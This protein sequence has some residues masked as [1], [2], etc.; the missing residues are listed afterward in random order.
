MEQDDLPAVPV[1]TKAQA[2][3]LEFVSERSFGWG[4]PVESI[5]RSPLLEDG[6]GVLLMNLIKMGLLGYPRGSQ[7]PICL[8]GF[9][10]RALA[11]FRR[12]AKAAMS[13]G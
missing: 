10:Q 9:G 11:R 12:K 6:D 13:D 1:I 5:E 3:V 7:D 2:R 4:V 8:T